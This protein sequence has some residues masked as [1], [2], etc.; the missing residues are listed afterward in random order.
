MAIKSPLPM[1]RDNPF[2][3]HGHWNA[4]DPRKIQ[5]TP[6]QL[7]GI[8]QMITDFLLEMVGVCFLGMLEN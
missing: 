8:P 3:I 6:E 2:P 5:Q 7:R 4:L 1:R